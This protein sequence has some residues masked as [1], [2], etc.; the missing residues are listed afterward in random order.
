MRLAGVVVLCVLGA[1]LGQESIY[2][3]ENEPVRNFVTLNT[4]IIIVLKVMA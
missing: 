1:A 4:Q 2:T 3:R